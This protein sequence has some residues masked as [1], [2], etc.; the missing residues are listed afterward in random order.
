VNFKTIICFAESGCVCWRD[1]SL[2][3]FPESSLTTDLPS[4]IYTEPSKSAAVLVAKGRVCEFIISYFL[5][6]RH[7]PHRK[8]KELPRVYCYRQ[9]VALISLSNTVRTAEKYNNWERNTQTT[10]RSHDTPN[11]TKGETDNKVI[12]WDSSQN[13]G[14]SKETAMRSQ[15]IPKKG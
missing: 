12:S 3:E 6:I 11:R 8:R 1:C 5:L 13:L 10:R 15:E 14:G 9:K 7:E 2:F 4:L